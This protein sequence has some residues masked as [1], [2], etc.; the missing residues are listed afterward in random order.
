MW[1]MRLVE[2]ERQLVAG[3]AT[4]AVNLLN[5]RRT[6]LS[7]G[8]YDNAVSVDSAWSLLKRER[9]LELHLEARR[10]GD[11]RRWISNGVL[12][13]YTDG[14]YRLNTTDPLSATPLRRT[15]AG[16]WRSYTSA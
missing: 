12:G 10:L 3:N 4:N 11:L 7:V 5:L 14:L 9:A 1:E 16:V 13:A 15:N 6:N 8:T 2:A